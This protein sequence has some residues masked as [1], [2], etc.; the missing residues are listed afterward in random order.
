MTGPVLEPEEVY[1]PV[2]PLND[3][4]VIPKIGVADAVPELKLIVEP[5][6]KPALVVVYP[7]PFTPPTTLA[8]AA[9]LLVSVPPLRVIGSVRDNP[10]RSSD[11]FALT[12]VPPGFALVPVP[13]VSNAPRA[14]TDPTVNVPP[15]IMVPPV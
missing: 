11:P 8:V 6:P 12:V 1:V 5:A 10:P 13:R 7:R 4:A 2:K 3:A 9:L 15:L 14:L